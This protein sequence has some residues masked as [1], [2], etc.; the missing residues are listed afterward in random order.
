MDPGLV[1]ADPQGDVREDGPKEEKCP[2]HLA[3]PDFVRCDSCK[4]IYKDLPSDGKA[5]LPGLKQPFPVT[6]LQSNTRLD[7]LEHQSPDG[8]LEKY[9]CIEDEHGKYKFA[10]SRQQDALELE[11]RKLQLQ[12]ERTNKARHEADHAAQDVQW[13]IA[14]AERSVEEMRCRRDG[15]MQALEVQVRQADIMLE[16]AQREAGKRLEEALGLKR[17]EEAHVVS[18]SQLL[19]AARERTRAAEEMYE[20]S[21]VAS[22]ARLAA[23]AAALAEAEEALVAQEDE[24][25]QKAAEH[26]QNVQE[27]CRAQ[28]EA[29]HEQS[30]EIKEAVSKRLPMESRRTAA[31]QEATETRRNDAHERLQK[32]RQTAGVHTTVMEED[33]SCMVRRVEL[34]EQATQR[35]LEEFAEGPVT[36]LERTAQ[37]WHGQSDRKSVCDKVSLEQTAW[38][39]GHHFKSRWNYTPS[40]DDKVTNILQGCLHGRD[41]KS[42][43]PHPSPRSLEPPVDL[44]PPPTKLPMLSTGLAGLEVYRIDRSVVLSMAFVQPCRS[45]ASLPRYWRHESS[46]VAGFHGHRSPGAEKASWRANLAGVAVGAAALHSQSRPASRGARNPLRKLRVQLRAKLDSRQ[47]SNTT[48][49]K[50]CSRIQMLEELLRGGQ[51]EEACALVEEMALNMVT[52]STSSYGSV[53]HACSKEGHVDKAALLLAKLRAM[54]CSP[55]VVSYGSVINGFAKAGRPEDIGRLMEDMDEDGV[56]V[57]VVMHNGMLEARR[58]KS[59]VLLNCFKRR[60][61]WI[62]E[63]ARSLLCKETTAETVSQARP[64]QRCVIPVEGLGFIALYCWLIRLPLLGILGCA[65]FLI[66]WKPGCMSRHEEDWH[67]QD[68]KEFWEMRI[69]AYRPDTADSASTGE[70]VKCIPLRPA[71]VALMQAFARAQNAEQAKDLLVRLEAEEG[72][73]DTMARTTLIEEFASHDSPEEARQ[74]TQQL[75]E[76]GNL[77][78]HVFGRVISACAKASKTDEAIQWFDNMV[79]ATVEPDAVAWN[80]IINACARVGRVTEAEM[81]LGEMEASGITPDVFSYTTVINAC[82]QSGRPQEAGAD[83]GRLFVRAVERLEMDGDVVPGSWLADHIRDSKGITHEQNIRSSIMLISLVAPVIFVAHAP[84]ADASMRQLSS[85]ALRS[86]V[87]DIAKKRQWKQALRLLHQAS[88]CTAQADLVCFNATISAC[89]KSKLWET[90]LSVLADIDRECLQK[91]L[92]SYNTSFS[93]IAVVEQ[94]RWSLHLLHDVKVRHLRSDIISFNTAIDGCQRKWGLSLAILAKMSHQNLEPDVIAHDTA[95]SSS[96]KGN[97]WD[98]ALDLLR[99]LEASFSREQSKSS[100]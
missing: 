13:Q 76:D 100:W 41:P 70:G 89:G 88:S 42:I 37:L 33:C 40:V 66:P 83:D 34:R 8:M 68:F 81:W 98:R 49:S 55:D 87:C 16:E 67:C 35:R 48:E 60:F 14:D 32:E 20:Q 30:S 28:L 78:V 69:P 94:W 36:A 21:K 79:S 91:D 1:H 61:K 7:V 85:S 84:H 10:R 46:T 29:V 6:A 56:P 23:R 47:A 97:Y 22:Q 80:G 96:E 43:L 5:P 50:E 90:S 72:Q 93:A 57:D 99:T 95:I 92:F 15:D 24:M 74:L 52:P 25:K 4:E 77:T 19:N 65:R 86:E 17:A 26:L 64:H 73:V 75:E 59:G 39:L 3:F 12:R 71:Y 51:A 82:A 58:I 11:R 18:S 45:D 63:R 54:E 53:I 9:Q 38:V 62:E 31:A 44:P 27:Q 2:M